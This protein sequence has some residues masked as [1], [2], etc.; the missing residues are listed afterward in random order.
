MNKSPI[1]RIN[2]V[3][4]ARGIALIAMAIFHFGWDLEN[5]GL[6]RAGMT[7]EPQWKYF[8]RTIASSFMFLVGLSAFLAHNRGFVPKTFIKRIGFVAL[9]AA[10]ITLTTYFATPQTFIF[11]GILHSIALSSV[12]ILVFL[13][14]PVLMVLL[15]AAIVFSAPF[16]AKTALLN[17]PIWWW[18]GLSQITPKAND[19]VPVFPWFGWVLLGLAFA[20][21][22]DARE[23]WQKLAA[24]KF[25][26]FPFTLFRFFGRNSLIFYLAHQPIMI[27]A[28]YIFVELSAGT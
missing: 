10:I 19:Y 2:A 17:A 24:P 18:S 1:P 25:N 6:A 14:L 26:V 3:D 4:L 21:L 16:W 22:L 27:G 11:F 12:L 23:L 9:A 20:K 5:F 13:R 15:S 7:L 8:A 28:L